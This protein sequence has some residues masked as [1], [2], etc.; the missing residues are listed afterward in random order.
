MATWLYGC[1]L[2][3]LV[4]SVFAIETKF[5]LQRL[6]ITHTCG[7]ETL[8]HRQLS[9]SELLPVTLPSALEDGHQLDVLVELDTGSLV[10]LEDLEQ[11]WIS[12][13]SKTTKREYLFLPCRRNHGSLLFQ[14]VSMRSMFHWTLECL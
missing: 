7:T 9:G 1:C 12:F 10:N 4:W 14:V 8:F 3:S 11:V 2:L 13:V 6:E 5:V